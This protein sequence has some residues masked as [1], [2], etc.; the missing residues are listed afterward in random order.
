MA[1]GYSKVFE[2]NR[3]SLSLQATTETKSELIH[4][5]GEEM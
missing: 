5:C 3:K 4:P 2:K 1:V